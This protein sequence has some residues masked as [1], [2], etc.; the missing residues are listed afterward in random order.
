MISYQ[1]WQDGLITVIKYHRQFTGFSVTGFE[2]VKNCHFP[3]FL[4]ITDQ[5]EGTV[6]PDYLINST[7]SS[8]K[9]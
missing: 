8:A 7:L 6:V 4:H 9:I 5:L 1:L 3:T 2:K